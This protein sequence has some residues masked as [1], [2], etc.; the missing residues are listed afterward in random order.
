MAQNLFWNHIL[1]FIPAPTRI[2]TF[3]PWRAL[4]FAATP[5]AAGRRLS[6][7]EQQH[8][9]PG[10]CHGILRRRNR[11]HTRSH[12]VRVQ[13]FIG[14]LPQYFSQRTILSSSFLTTS[15]HSVV[16]RNIKL[17]KNWKFMLERYPTCF[18]E[19]K[20]CQI[21]RKPAIQNNFGINEQLWIFVFGPR[22]TKWRLLICN[23]P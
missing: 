7:H 15:R 17:N 13:L 8:R 18:G 1:H 23:D 9:R 3:R 16:E 20:N 2:G 6:Q 12:C 5:W 10:K 4:L 22:A 21:T 14:A 19:G 11:H